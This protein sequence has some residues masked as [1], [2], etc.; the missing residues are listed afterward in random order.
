M[1]DQPQAPIGPSNIMIEPGL[2]SEYY[3]NQVINANNYQWHLNPIESGLI[4]GLDT[5]AV[6]HWNE[7][8]TGSAAYLNVEAINNCGGTSS[9]TLII[10]LS[11]VELDEA[12][13]TDEQISIR[14]N[15][16]DGIFN[17]GIKSNVDEIELTVIN[18]NSIKIRQHKIKLSGH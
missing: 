8:F 15:P 11:P 17:I 14:P 18:S 6:I 10:N 12:T 4:S 7:Y 16:S 2:T 9:D 13:W 1:P 5:A 3:T